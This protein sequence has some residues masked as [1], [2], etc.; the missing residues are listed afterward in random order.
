MHILF[1]RPLDDCSEIILKFNSL[2]HKVS[3]LPLLNISIVDYNLEDFSDYKGI[4][5]TSANAVKFLNLKNVD[6]KLV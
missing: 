1:T 5:F 6:K 2:G 4:I 3:H